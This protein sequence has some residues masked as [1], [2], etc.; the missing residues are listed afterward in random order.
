MINYICIL[1]I[2]TS[3]V[4]YKL[5]TF[6]GRFSGT[7]ITCKTDSTSFSN[8]TIILIKS[9]SNC[10]GRSCRFYYN[11]NCDNRPE[12]IDYGMF[13]P[14]NLILNIKEKRYTTLNAPRPTDPN[15][16]YGDPNFTVTYNFD[17]GKLKY[18]KKTSVLTLQSIKYNWTRKY[19]IEYSSKDSILTLK[20]KS[21]I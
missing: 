20:Y 13:W 16:K 17:T 12:Y 2:F 10:K 19:N 11:P 7:I 1:L 3:C 18:N 21:D 15:L 6:E 8:D 9:D 5:P 14:A 4:N